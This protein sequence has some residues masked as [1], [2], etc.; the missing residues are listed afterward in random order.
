MGGWGRGKATVI[1]EERRGRDEV[2]EL[3]SAGN[4]T[5]LTTR[6]LWMFFKRENGHQ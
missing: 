4:A 6:G 5:V 2:M 3:S 1:G